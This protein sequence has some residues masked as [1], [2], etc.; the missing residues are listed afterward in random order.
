M[1][2]RTKAGT[3][4]VGGE[5]RANLLPPEVLVKRKAKVVRRRLGLV[6]ILLVVLMLGGTAWTRALA[7]QARSNLAIERANTHSLLVLER[8]YVEVRKVQQQVDLIQAAQQVGAATEINWELYLNAVQATL[9]TN[10]SLD[11]I[12]KRPHHFKVRVLRHS[13][14]LRRVPPCRRYRLGLM[15]SWRF[16]AT[17]MHHLDP[18]LATI[19]APTA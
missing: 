9:P 3:V 2:G 18:L 10:V 19:P 7:V 13:V 17:P 14:L 8:K 16:L 11:T 5:S 12:H 1:I 15:H 4:I 6:V